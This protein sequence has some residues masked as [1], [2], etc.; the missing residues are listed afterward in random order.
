MSIYDNE[1]KIYPFLN[2]MAPKESQTYRLSK[3]SEIE[4]F[5]L[6]EIEKCE[7]K[8]KKTKQTITILSIAD[9]S[10][11]TSTVLTGGI[12]NQGRTAIKNT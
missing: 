11:I 2:P 5:F 9:T 12:S 6:N 3:L 4:A 1:T 7:Q 10:L 8:I